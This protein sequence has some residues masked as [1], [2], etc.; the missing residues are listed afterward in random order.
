MARAS[1]GAP[2][3][4]VGLGL[5]GASTVGALVLTAGKPQEPSPSHTPPPPKDVP[6]RDVEALARM[7]AS[8]NPGGSDALLIEQAFTQLRQ[9]KTSLHARITA[10]SGYGQQGDAASGGGVRPVSSDKMPSDKHLKLATEVLAGAHR[11]KWAGADNFFEPSQ[12][13]KAFAIA[14]TARKKQAAGIAL[15]EQEKRLIKYK[16]NADGI[17]QLRRADGFTLLGAIDGVEFWGRPQ[18]N[19]RTAS[20]PIAQGRSMKN[21]FLWPVEQKSITRIGDGVTLDRNGQGRPHQGVDIFVP[22][23][24][25]VVAAT[26]GLVRAV[27]DGRGSSEEGKRRAGLWCDVEYADYIVRYLHLGDC[28]VKKGDSLVAGIS[29]IGMVAPPGQ[30]GTGDASHLHFE[31]RRRSKAGYGD[32]LNPLRLLPRRSVSNA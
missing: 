23:Y 7:F 10:G 21:T 24:T 6:E 9:V 12:Q 31:V 28:F 13:D 30:S 14:E 16:H 2:W 17:R 15:S 27:V 18:S 11:P 20:D 25:V 5:L 32:P 1:D 29:S 26:D 8:E 22:A 3:V 19:T 4:W